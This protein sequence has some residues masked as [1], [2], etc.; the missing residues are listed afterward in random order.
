MAGGVVV[1]VAPVVARGIAT[2]GGAPVAG[3]GEVTLIRAV[4][5]AAVAATDDVAGPARYLAPEVAGQGPRS[6]VARGGLFVLG[7]LVVAGVIYFVTTS[8]SRVQDA[9]PSGESPPGGAPPPGDDDSIDEPHDAG[10]PPAKAPGAA[11]AEPATAPGS[12][13]PTATEPSTPPPAALPGASPSDRALA[14]GDADD[15]RG[16]AERLENLERAGDY[17]GS[18]PV[19]LRERLLSDRPEV[20]RQAEQELRSLE[21]AA[22]AQRTPDAEPAPITRPFTRDAAFEALMERYPKPLNS[23]PYNRHPRTHYEPIG[24]EDE[25]SSVPGQR[26]HVLVIRGKQGD[27]ANR[28]LRFSVSWT[29][30]TGQFEDIHE[31]S[32]R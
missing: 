21:A 11:P 4:A 3:G 20:R 18:D 14:G 24:W 12:S 22:H 13:P 28:Q 1:G 8:I 26:R 9:R 15:R 16:N 29:E 25:Q 10:A 7:T 31:A 6:L 17:A 2:I 5:R 30:A 32:G 23:E 27:V 19:N